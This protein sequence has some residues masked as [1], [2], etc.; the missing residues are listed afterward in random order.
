MPVP[1]SRV[2][3]LTGSPGML[4]GHILASSLALALVH[5]EDH[6]SNRT[7][8]IH[9]HNT[10]TVDTFLRHENVHVRSHVRQ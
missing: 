1:A 10:S 6:G 8:N 7:M 9:R 2:R 4:P 3:V 5:T